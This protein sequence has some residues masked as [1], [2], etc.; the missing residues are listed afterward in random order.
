MDPDRMDGVSL[1]PEEL[2]QFVSQLAASPEHWQHLIRHS[3]EARHYELIWDDEDVNAWLI[4]WSPGQDTG[5]HDHEDSSAGIAVV[6]G[7]V[8]EQR[9]RLG[10]PPQ[11]HELA[12]G[13]IRSVPPDAIHRVLHAGEEPAVTIHAY[14]PPLRRTGAYRVGPDGALLRTAQ[15]SEIELRVLSALS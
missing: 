11:C 2:E 5:F 12:A 1:A 15:A 13:A 4:C 6:A 14:S 8:Q 10:S 7:R 3:S 9:L